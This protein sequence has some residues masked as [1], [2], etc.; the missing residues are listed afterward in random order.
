MEPPEDKSKQF[1]LALC[2]NPNVGKTTLFNRLT[3]L[4]AQT[5]NFPGTT[6]E[7]KIGTLKL[8]DEKITVLDLP[9]MYSFNAA[10]AEEQ[11]SADVL[12]GR[13][14]G[15]S[16]PDGVVV[17]ADADNM[18]RSLFLISQLSDQEIPMIVALNMVDI[19]NRHGV[20]VDTTALSWDLGCPVVEIVAN[21]GTGM[22]TLRA[23]IAKLVAGEENEFLIHPIKHETPAEA[24]CGGC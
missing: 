14:K 24:A 10:T 20:H 5:A 23:E 6:I 11:I 2:G 16:K 18:E 17:L 4:R 9:G 15:M 12:V 22:D 19:A 7:R 3:G 21:T 1:M 13:A 8:G